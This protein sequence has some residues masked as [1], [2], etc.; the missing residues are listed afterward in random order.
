MCICLKTAIWVFLAFL[1]QG[2][3][4]FGEDRLVNLL[5]NSARF[6]LANLGV[7]QPVQLHTYARLLVFNET[8]AQPHF[9]VVNCSDAVMSV[10]SSPFPTRSQ[11]FIVMNSCVVALGLFSSDILTWSANSLYSV[12]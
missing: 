1:G 12:Q 3:I 11:N 8:L 4:F 5:C 9:A 6:E 2:L 7:R 10:F